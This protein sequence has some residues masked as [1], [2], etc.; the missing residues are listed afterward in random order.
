[1]NDSQIVAK[2]A[3]DESIFYPEFNQ[4][5]ERCAHYGYVFLLLLVWF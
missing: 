2:D 3:R 1:M 5:K 4:L